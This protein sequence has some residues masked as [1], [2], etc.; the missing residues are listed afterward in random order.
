MPDL[1]DGERLRCR[2][3][4]MKKL[5]LISALLLTITGCVTDGGFMGLNHVASH[6]P[7]GED[8]YADFTTPGR[9]GFKRASSYAL[10]P[11]NK[12]EAIGI[13]TGYKYW[14]GNLAVDY[15]PNE[16][17][18]SNADWQYF[19]NQGRK[20]KRS[21]EHYVLYNCEKALLEKCVLTKL[22]NRV[23]SDS[24]NIVE[25][26]EK[27]TQEIEERKRVASYEKTRLQQQKWKEEA[28]EQNARAE[29][30][31]LAYLEE[32]RLY[33]EQLAR[34]ETLRREQEEKERR[35]QEQK[36][37]AG[38]RDRCVSFGFTGDNNIAACIQR[39]AQH[40]LEIEQ[41][42]YEL[43]LA[44]QRLDEQYTQTRIAQQR[45]ER[46]NTQT[47]LAQQRLERQSRQTQVVEEE[48][49]WII[50]FLGDVA[51]GVSEGYAQGAI[52]NSQH[53]NQ[54]QDIYRNCRPNCNPRTE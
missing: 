44:Q 24:R 28:A 12:G 23:L 1:V 17:D 45:L 32:E 7:A 42:K 6:T 21:V 50:R 47:Q 35:E 49:P 25:R 31:R 52:H 39:E 30:Q 53:Q 3:N 16:Y 51:V 46:Q 36:I 41:Q 33:N 9:Y 40:E 43:R 22:G 15:F 26:F 19:L 29:E 13:N 20:G 5:L 18:S 2:I 8:F 34:E 27:E 54:K 38:L 11:N 4:S 14:L 10:I 48:V 37:L